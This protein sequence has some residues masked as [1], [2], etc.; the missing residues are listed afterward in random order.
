VTLPGTAGGPADTLLATVL[1]DLAV[2]TICALALGALAQRVG[3]AAV[4]GEIVAGLVLG[5]SVL[6]LLPG[7]LDALLFPRAVYSYLQILADVALVLFVFSVGFEVDLGRM[8]RSGRAAV[9]V[10]SASVVVPA[11]AAMAIAPALWTAHPPVAGVTEVQFAAFL[12]VVLSVTALP[13]LARMVADSWLSG[14]QLG[15]LAL[16]AAGMTDLV[17][18][19]A[20]ALVTATLGATEGGVPIG[21]LAVALPG[22]LVVLV[23]VIRP[24]LRWGLATTPCRRS[25]SAG[26]SLLLVGALALCA[27][28]TTALGLHPVFG[29][30]ALGVACPRRSASPVASRPGDATVNQP[31]ADPSERVAAAVRPISSAGLLLVPVYFIVTGLNVDVTSLGL[32]GALEVCGLVVLATATKVAGVTLAAVRSGLDLGR[33]LGLGLLLNTRGLTELIVLDIGRRAGVIDSRLF[34]ILVLVAILTTAMT[35]PLLP[36]ALRIGRKTKRIGTPSAGRGAVG[37]V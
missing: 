35:M 31:T 25:S 23:L 20:L 32:D 4:V 36:F 13:V 14:T 10:A 24:L 37:R 28:A 6:G 16:V 5:P 15:S 1:L 27:A 22:F 17:A 2:I 8:R 30:F 34:T 18:W 11:I 26:G 7:H 12:A 3:Q 21:V 9:R 29:A 33:S 19:V